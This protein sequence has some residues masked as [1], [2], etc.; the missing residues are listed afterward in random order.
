M[1]PVKIACAAAIGF[2]V[3]GAVLGGKKGGPTPVA[4]AATA[5]TAPAAPELH[6]IDY[7]CT[8]EHG[9]T[10]TQGTVRNV[11]N[12][13]IDQLMVVGVHF[14][15]SNEFIKSDNAMVEY[16]PLMP[17]QTSPFKT[18]SSYNPMMSKCNVGF[19]RMFG[20]EIATSR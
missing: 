5:P 20:G 8:F 2:I 17:G 15:S 14:S 7:K 1:T 11:S 3:V 18:M 19:K 6:L 4:A 13:P 12:K 16:Q 10:T 9:Y